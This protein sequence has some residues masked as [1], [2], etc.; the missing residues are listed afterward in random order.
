MGTAIIE[1]LSNKGIRPKRQILDNEAS[2]DYLEQITKHGIEWEKV[3][4]HNHRRNLAEKAIQTAKGHITANMV[5]CDES[6]PMR[7]WHRIIPQIELTLN[8]L[9]ASNIRPTI[10]AHTYVHGLH[11]YNK[12]PLAP[13]GCKTQC[14]VGPDQRTSYGEHSMDSWY[15]GTS[16]EHYRCYR[17]YMKATRAERITDTILFRHKHLTS[18]SVTKADAITQAAHELTATLKDNVPKKLGELDMK[19]LERLAKIFEKAAQAVSENEAAS[20]R[21]P[22]PRV[23]AMT[24]PSPRVQD[25]PQTNAANPR[26][27]SQDEDDGPPELLYRG[28]VAPAHML[29]ETPTGVPRRSKRLQ[30]NITTEAL[31]SI[32]ELSTHKLQPQKLAQR[33]F[34]NQ[35]LYEMAGAVMDNETGDML[36]YRHLLKNPKYRDTWSKAFGKEI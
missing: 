18:P 20:P 35:L 33:K 29:R 23:P 21:V 30:G 12:T 26:V 13:I 7:E 17:V 8:M 19:D 15:I 9:R 14:F 1:R 5:G 11:D 22:S 34:P 31:L 6:F 10:S 36:E 16:N 2:D 25:S 27:I 24:A 28:R 32:V 3:P 4:P